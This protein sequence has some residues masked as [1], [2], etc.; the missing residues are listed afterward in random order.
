M[1]KVEISLYSFDELNGQAKDR[2]IADHIGF[3][4][5]LPEEFED[6]DGIMC[7]EYIEHTE[8]QAIESIQANEYLFFADGT[9]ANVTQ[10]C[11]KHPRA[12]QA[13][14]TLHGETITWVWAET[15]GEF[16]PS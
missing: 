15:L 5:S 2:A 6:A 7:S 3:L 14:L 1:R 10:Y 13:E 11:G 12:G 16:F 8:E 4:D 9:L